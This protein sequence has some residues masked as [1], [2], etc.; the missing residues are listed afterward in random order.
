MTRTEFIEDVNDFY[1]L[2]RFCDDE[3]S[4]ICDEIFA[5]DELRERV[6][7]DLESLARSYTWDELRD[8]LNE[9]PEDNDWYDW[10]F[11]CVDH[12]FNDYKDDVLEWGDENG[13]WDEEA[14]DEDGEEETGDEIIDLC[15]YNAVEMFCGCQDDFREIT[16]SMKHE[17][18]E[19]DEQLME[20]IVV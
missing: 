3:G 7:D 20:L 1:D 2:K 16:L 11:R 6:N 15:G 10:D 9:V 17:R 18:Q 14:E 19:M 5:G 13:I 12:L 8:Y 4:S